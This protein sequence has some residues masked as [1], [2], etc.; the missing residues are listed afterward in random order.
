MDVIVTDHH[1]PLDNLP[2]A[3]AVVDCKRK[4]NKYPF[5]SLAGVGVAFKLIQAISQKLKLSEK[6]YLKY[7]DI[8]CV[9][10]ISDIVPLIDENRV[11]AKLGLMLA[12]ET[13]N[14][15]L[16]SLIINSGYKDVNSNTISFGIAPRI[17][18]CGRMGFENEAL[19]LFLNEDK[20]QVLEITEKL[21]SYNK[22]RQETEKRIFDEVIE[23]IEAENL[24]EKNAIVLA[25]KGWHHGVIKI[26]GLK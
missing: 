10:T 16:K 14:F 26:V 21:N 2:K 8:V 25:G 23:K 6:D 9:G 15:G 18:A 4:D 17:N 20:N 11:I 1:E 5:N 7:L 3:I 12:A 19:N 24:D 22:E 13:R